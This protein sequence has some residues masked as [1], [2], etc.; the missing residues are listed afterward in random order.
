MG[1][2]EYTQPD[3]SQ[4]DEQRHHR[5]ERDQELG[6]HPCG[7]TRDEPDD[8]AEQP[9]DAASGPAEQSDTRARADDALSQGDVVRSDKIRSKDL[10]NLRYGF[11]TRLRRS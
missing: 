6:L 3:R 4:H 5:Q 9:S 11:P 8:V 1:I 10:T 2:A 7:H